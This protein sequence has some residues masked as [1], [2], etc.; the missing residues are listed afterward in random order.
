MTR[1]MLPITETAHLT[2]FALP[3]VYCG[4][5]CSVIGQQHT[6]YGRDNVHV[7]MSTSG[8]MQH[9]QPVQEEANVPLQNTFRVMHIH[10]LK[11][12]IRHL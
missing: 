7:L 6:A 12:M 3:T 10:V 4:L 9:M 11:S 2:S 1:S 8:N 5:T